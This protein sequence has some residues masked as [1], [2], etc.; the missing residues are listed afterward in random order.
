[1]KFANFPWQI[2]I[3]NFDAS[4][5]FRARV[6]RSF[7]T[8]VLMALGTGKCYGRTLWAQRW[9]FNTWKISDHTDTHMHSNTNTWAF[10]FNGE[11]FPDIHVQYGTWYKGKLY[12]RFS[13]SLVSQTHC[14]RVVFCLTIF[15]G[16]SHIYTHSIFV[17]AVT[18][19][20]P[21]HTVKPSHEI[22]TFFWCAILYF[23][24]ACSR[25]SMSLWNF[26]FSMFYLHTFTR[27]CYVSENA[28]ILWFVLH[29]RFLL[30]LTWF[31]SDFSSFSI[32]FYMYTRLRPCVTHLFVLYMCLCVQSI[33]I[34]NFLPFRICWC[35]CGKMI[36]KS[37]CV[38]DVVLFVSIY[39]C[40]CVLLYI[41]YTMENTF[42]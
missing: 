33:H 26:P 28:D 1:M 37:I 18:I 17:F 16:K 21:I 11:Y 35:C 4:K 7:N 38:V 25:L 30:S 14:K 12:N 13:V 42:T 15:P 20:A 39:I 34:V 27:G 24:T 10:I 36:W 9:K 5:W 31:S 32:T 2:T 3:R 23:L 6:F 19:N 40:V 8:T 22:R 41:D 29:V